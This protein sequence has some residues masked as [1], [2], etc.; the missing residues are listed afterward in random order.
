MRTEDERRREGGAISAT[1][2]RKRAQGYQLEDGIDEIGRK[3]I[4]WWGRT[5]GQAVANSQVSANTKGL[6]R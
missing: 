2:V 6:A 4:I 1:V 5:V 3:E